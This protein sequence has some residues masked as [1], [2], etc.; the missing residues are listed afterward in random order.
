M[1]LDPS[2]RQR[3]Q[4]D[5]WIGD[6]VL[7]L[8][9]R[10]WILA[11]PHVAPA[12]RSDCFRNITSNQFLAALGNPSLI[13]AEIGLAYKN[14][15]LAAANRYFLEKLVPLFEKQQRNRSRRA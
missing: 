6:A 4:D 14:G 5:S 7:A 11:Q 9:A 1:P 12:E 3:I 10:E 15:G 13:E 8:L 2:A